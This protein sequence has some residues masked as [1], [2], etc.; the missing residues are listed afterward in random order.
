MFLVMYGPRLSPSLPKGIKNL[1][2]SSAFRFLLILLIVFLSTKNLQASFILALAF[3]LTTSFVT[4]NSIKENFNKNIVENYTS[5]QTEPSDY[6]DI[7]KNL[8]TPQKRIE[9]EKFIAKEIH[10]FTALLVFA[11]CGSS[12]GKKFKSMSE[13]MDILLDKTFKNIDNRDLELKEKGITP[14]SNCN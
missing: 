9:D 1:F 2:N 8:T 5:Q 6:K 12:L 7:Y 14:R 3:I 4:S 13:C 10:N 11:T